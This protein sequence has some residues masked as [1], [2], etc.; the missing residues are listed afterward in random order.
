MQ[1]PV[2]QFRAQSYSYLACLFMELVSF[3]HI[4]DEKSLKSMKKSKADI[5]KQKISYDGIR[6]CLNDP[7]HET[8]TS[9]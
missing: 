8:W 3:R 2:N 6:K 4:C 7:W 1:R 5:Y 9:Q